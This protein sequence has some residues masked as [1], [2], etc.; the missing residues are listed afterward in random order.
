MSYNNLDLI[1]LGLFGSQV[2]WT[3]FVMFLALLIL[4]FLRATNIVMDSYLDLRAS[5]LI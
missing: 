4:N 3:I 5:N 1:R 2:R